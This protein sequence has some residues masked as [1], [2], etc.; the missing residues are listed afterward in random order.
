MGCEILIV[1]T[2]ASYYLSNCNPADNVGYGRVVVV[3]L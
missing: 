1:T 2:Q 3:S